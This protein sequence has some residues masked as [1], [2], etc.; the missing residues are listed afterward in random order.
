MLSNWQ[1]TFLK[2]LM[3]SKSRIYQRKRWHLRIFGWV[4]CELKITA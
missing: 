1:V 4:I 2:D 3:A